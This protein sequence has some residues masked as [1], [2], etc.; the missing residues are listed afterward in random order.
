MSPPSVAPGA[1]DI[2][3]TV[4]RAF[5]V[6]HCNFLPFFGCGLI[7]SGLPYVVIGWFQSQTLAGG[8]PA[9]PTKVALIG[10]AALPVTMVSYAVMQASI[11]HG[12]IADMNGRRISFAECLT[13]ALPRLLP[14]LGVSILAGLAA[15]FATLLLIIPGILVA[16]AYSV[17]VPVAVVERPGVFAAL[18][19]S[20]F[21]T[22]NNRASIFVV[23][24]LVG[25]L[26]FIV[27]LLGSA[28]AGAIGAASPLGFIRASYLIGTPLAQSLVSVLGSS[29]SASIYYELRLIKEGIGAEELAAVFD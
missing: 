3:R 1:F 16:L 9:D 22:R 4:S 10:L 19:R 17:A 24:L 8:L 27:G 28:I 25:V 20:A 14:L 7:L 12:S 13:A 15:G 23:L 21:L 2:G 6:L 26:S 18:E 5:G 29:V 11:I